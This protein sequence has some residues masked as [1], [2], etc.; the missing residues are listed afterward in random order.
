MH[1]Q[2]ILTCNVHIHILTHAHTP[3][4]HIPT[5]EYTHTYPQPK[6]AYPHFLTWT[7]GTL[8][9]I[10]QKVAWLLRQKVLSCLKRC[11]S[12]QT[13]WLWIHFSLSAGAERIPQKQSDPQKAKKGQANVTQRLLLCQVVTGGEVT[14]TEGPQDR[15]LKYS[16]IKA[17]SSLS[18]TQGW[19]TSKR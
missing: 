18:E 12:G 6:K 8:A 2:Y 9:Q 13:A 7:T 5:H 11:F 17:T 15:V 3:H 4:S 14:N 10:Q 1:K 16:I 19:K